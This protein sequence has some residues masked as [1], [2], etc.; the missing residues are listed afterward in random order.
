MGGFDEHEGSFYNL[1]GS[2]WVAV[3]PQ[4]GSQ[5]FQDWQDGI[6][7]G[8]Q[9]FCHRERLTI[10]TFGDIV[11]ARGECRV[12]FVEIDGPPDGGILTDTLRAQDR[13]RESEGS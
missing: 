13:Q 1:L 11:L 10:L 7:I 9:L 2:G 3:G 4:G 5:R 6:G 12:A 8:V